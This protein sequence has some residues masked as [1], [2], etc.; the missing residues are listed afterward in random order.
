MGVVRLF[1]LISVFAQNPVTET[2]SFTLTAKSANVAQPGSPV[3]VVVF[4]WSSEEE[5]NRIVTPLDPAAQAAAQA[6]ALA[7]GRGRGGRGTRGQASGASGAGGLDPDDPALAEVIARGLGARGRGDTAAKPPDPIAEFTGTLAKAPTVGYIWTD[8]V[9][10]Y[11]IKYARRIPLPNGGERIVLA[12]DR[13]L[14]A[15]TPAW[16]PAAGI[17]TDY[18]FTVIEIHVDSKGFGEAKASLTTKVVLD[19]ENKALALDGYAGAP[20]IF[21]NLKH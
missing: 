8:E 14:G 4:R 9:V 18:E 6:A 5:R 21:Q 17:P 7:E 20:A 12:T 1:L 11:S 2:D 3:K 13:R 15:G 10:G 19:N 16:K